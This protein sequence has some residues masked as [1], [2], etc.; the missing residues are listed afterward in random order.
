[1]EENEQLQT[2]NGLSYIL[3]FILFICILV[4]VYFYRSYEFIANKNF[5]NNYTKNYDITF[6]KLPYYTQSLYIT[7]E[8]SNKKIGVVKKQHKEE[9]QLLKDKIVALE[10]TTSNLQKLKSKV[11]IKEVVKLQDVVKIKEVVKIKT[12]K[13]FIAPKKAT[14]HTTMMCKDMPDKKMLIS[15]QCLKDIQNFALTNKKALYFEVI[16]YMAKDEFKDNQIS[17]SA[18]SHRRVTNGIWALRKALNF[19]NKVLPVNYTITSKH[20]FQRGVIIRAY[21]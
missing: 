14:T 6:E 8:Q 9:I 18:L 2:N 1:M 17:K 7:K 21:H 10:T 11:K 20:N 19:K 13:E 3:G 12:I 15:K 5:K 16:A 4:F